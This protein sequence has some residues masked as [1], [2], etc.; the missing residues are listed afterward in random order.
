MAIKL[1]K[2]CYAI[3]HECYRIRRNN[4]KL[5]PLRR[6]RSL[7]VTDFDTNWKP[8][9][10][11]LL[12]INGNLPPILHRFQVV[13]DYN[14]KFSLLTEGRFILTPSLGV[15]SWENCHKW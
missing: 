9:C 12:V 1:I 8:I 5:W 15:I 2:H 7:K 4:A 6:S 14:V 3:G 11:I 10:G 13:T